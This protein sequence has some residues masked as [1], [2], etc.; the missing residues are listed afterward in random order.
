MEKITKE[1]FN[2]LTPENQKLILSLG[3]EIEENSPKPEKNHGTSTRRSTDSVLQKYACV[4]ETT[5]KLCKNITTTV[6]S[7]Q[8]V[9]GLLTS[10]QASLDQIEGMTVKT[11]TETVI[12]CPNCRDYLKTLCLEDLISLTIKAAKGDCRCVERK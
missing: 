4:V 12:T 9:G 5:C 8:G 6:F 1:K 7:M 2:S 3:F 11:R 10:H